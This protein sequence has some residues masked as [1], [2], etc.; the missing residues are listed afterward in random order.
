MAVSILGTPQ[1]GVNFE[2]GTGLD[3]EAV[4]GTT[5]R[6][7][8]VIFG[9]KMGGTRTISALTLGGVNMAALG[10]STSNFNLTASLA[11][12]GA[13]REANIP[14]GSN[15]LSLTLSGTDADK[16]QGVIFT[17]DG[18][19][20]TT[21]I[22]AAGTTL[23]HTN[24]AQTLTEATGVAYTDG[25]LVIAHWTIDNTSTP[26]SITG[27]AGYTGLYTLDNANLYT[28]AWYQ[29]MSGSGTATPSVSFTNGTGTYASVLRTSVIK[30]ASAGSSVAPLAA[31][32]YYNNR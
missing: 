31:A 9:S 24:G 15:T 20:Q 19:D 16:G 17:L 10:G 8:V 26:T 4:A 2:A 14:G 23:D 21:A 28:R 6:M 7:V 1:T 11:G 25:D 30:A 18:C 32:Y 13:I 22:S 12:L 27:P 29:I 3:Y 5:E